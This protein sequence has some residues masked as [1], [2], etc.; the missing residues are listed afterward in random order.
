MDGGGGEEIWG[1]ISSGKAIWDASRDLDPSL[2][3]RIRS[4]RCLV[5]GV[6]TT[7]CHVTVASQRV[8]FRN[9]NRDA[10]TVETAEKKQLDATNRM[11]HR[12]GEKREGK[13]SIGDR[14]QPCTKSPLSYSY[15]C[16]VTRTG[17]HCAST[18]PYPSLLGPC[19][20]HDCPRYALVLAA[21]MIVD[22]RQ[23]H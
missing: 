8:M 1:L 20:S 18:V 14:G 4:G 9:I 22:P 5:P 3:C 7:N 21:L 12:R 17:W 6:G 16:A 23:H 19:N 11:S 2:N 13:T 10:G 15:Y